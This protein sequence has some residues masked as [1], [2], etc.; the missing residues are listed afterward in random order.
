MIKSFAMSDVAPPE[1]VNPGPLKGPRDLKGKKVLIVD[2]S[3]DN[4]RLIRH[5]LVKKQIECSFADN[6]KEA[7]EKALSDSFDAV[8]MDMQMPVMDGYTATQNLRSQ[9]YR[10]PIIALTAHAMVEDRQRCIDVG[11]NDYL[12]KPVEAMKLYKTLE[13]LIAPEMVVS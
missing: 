8:L 10:V 12:T 5:Y 1:I 7:M 2:D 11:C 13:D 4:Q 3:S 9:N 6:G